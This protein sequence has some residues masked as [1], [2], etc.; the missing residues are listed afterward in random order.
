MEN[1]TP[2]IKQIAT[3]HGVLL[4]LLSILMLVIMYVANL[5]KNWALSIVSL[6]VTILIFMSAIKTFKATNNGYL[7]VGEAIK[8]GL[9]TAAIGGIIGAVYTYLHYTFVYPEFIE[10]VLDTAREQILKQNPDMAQEQMDMAMT[11]S[12]KF[13]SPFMMATVSLIG[14]LFIGFIISIITGLIMQK[15]DTLS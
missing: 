12:K 9:A 1:T 11:M 2:S 5:E 15:K 13:S 3:N 7:T 14:S 6:L 10:I 4:A 8:V